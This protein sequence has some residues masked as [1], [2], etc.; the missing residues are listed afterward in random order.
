MIKVS[1]ETILGDTCGKGAA[2]VVLFA[3]EVLLVVLSSCCCGFCVAFDAEGN[4]TV[5]ESAKVWSGSC[6][7]ELALLLFGIFWAAVS[8]PIFEEGV[9]ASVIRNSLAGHT[10]NEKP[11][12]K[13]EKR[14][15]KQKQIERPSTQYIHV[16][17]PFPDWS[18]V[19]GWPTRSHSQRRTLSLYDDRHDPWERFGKLLRDTK[20]VATLKALHT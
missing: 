1:F 4:G 15:R 14:K 10:P 16:S 17:T 5:C 8:D 6:S 18:G 7:T 19:A 20:S 9:E 12:N 13:K 11:R 2:F 3:V